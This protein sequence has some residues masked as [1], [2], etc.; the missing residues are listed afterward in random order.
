LKYKN[1]WCTQ[2]AHDRATTSYSGAIFGVVTPA[3][4]PASIASTVGVLT[5][6]CK[7]KHT[8]SS[9]TA[10]HSHDNWHQKEPLI[11]K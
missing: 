6:D 5:D 3:R 1:T 9:S 7:Q 10:F 8:A 2:T 11:V 4:R